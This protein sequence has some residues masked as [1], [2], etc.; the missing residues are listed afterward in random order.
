MTDHLDLLCR[1]CFCQLHHSFALQWPGLLQFHL[2]R[3][4]K[5][6]VVP[7]P[8]HSELCFLS[9][10]Q[11]AK[12]FPYIGIHVRDTALALFFRAHSIQD[13]PAI[14]ASLVSTTLAFFSKVCATVRSQM[15][16]QMHSAT[17]GNIYRHCCSMLYCE[18][19]MFSHVFHPTDWLYLCT[20]AFDSVQYTF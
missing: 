16:Q 17:H 19:I 4:A 5:V 15:S 2:S 1:S 9:R 18:P 6:A 13:H 11:Q 12:V 8:V 3:S 7:A 10:G 14:H 20:V